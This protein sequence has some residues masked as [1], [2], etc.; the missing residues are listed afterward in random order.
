MILRRTSDGIYRDCNGRFR[1]PRGAP[2]MCTIVRRPGTLFISSGY[3]GA[4]L[5]LTLGRN[6]AATHSY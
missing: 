6:L 2:S 1:R 5:I 3:L 4:A